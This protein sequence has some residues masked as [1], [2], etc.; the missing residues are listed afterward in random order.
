MAYENMDIDVIEK[1]AK[2]FDE[3][4]KFEPSLPFQV[5]RGMGKVFSLFLGGFS[6]D[7]SDDTPKDTRDPYEEMAH[8][9]GV[10]H[11]THVSQAY[12]L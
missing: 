10:R 7:G 9:N 2:E 4:N 11:Y 8:R 12:K 1:L 3:K 5:F 6:S